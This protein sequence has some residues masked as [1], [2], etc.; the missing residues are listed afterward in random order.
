MDAEQLGL[1]DMDRAHILQ[2]EPVVDALA[3]LSADR[4]RTVR[5]AQALA[6]G[7]HPL[8]GYALHPEAAPVD[9]RK[10]PG[11]RCGNCWHRTAAEWHDRTHL[12]CGWTGPMGADEVTATAPPRVTHGAASD[13]RNWWPG[14]GEHEWGETQLSPDAARWVPGPEPHDRE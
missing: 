10:A 7:R 3:G 4:R 11:R 5:Q 14:C 6:A 13:L 1:F 2:P 8:T 9:D 12:K